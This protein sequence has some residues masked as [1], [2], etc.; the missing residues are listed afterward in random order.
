MNKRISPILT[1]LA[2]VINAFAIGSTEFISVGL[3]PLIVNS[4]HVTL[5][6]AGL[7]VSLYAIGVTIGAPL[8]T[9]L[10]GK[11]NR[12]YLMIVIML[13]FIIGNLVAA[14]ALSFS[15]LLGGRIISALAHGLFMS[16][17]SV[18]AADVVEPNK[19]ASAIA[20][21][22]TGLTVAT[23]T[24]VPLG[25][26][27]GQ[28]TNWHFTFIFIAIIGA[29]GL[30]ANLF[31]IP[32][33]LPIPGVVDLRGIIRIFKNKF[34]LGS[35]IVTALGY[36]GTFAAYTYL[37]PILEDKIGYSAHAVVLL[38]VVYG[39]M[40]AIGN[41]IGG[42][43][44]NKQ[45]LKSLSLMFG[46]LSLSLVFLFVAILS[47]QLIL[48]TLA[49]LVLGLFSFMNVPGLQLYVVQLAE[50]YTPKDI[51]LAS[52]FNISAF[53][54]GIAFGSF[55]GA[56]VTKSIGVTYTPIFGAIIVLLA[57]FLVLQLLHITRKTSSLKEK[58][59]E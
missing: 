17:S 33:H 20:I 42:H 57:V 44:S 4:F 18:I 11:W 24:G 2:L 14:F 9:V 16:V 39:I 10:T 54:I 3:M 8:L 5:A 47:N 6:Q 21:M 46:L 56:Q 32:K 7:T 1:L 53:N 22:F 55:V 45:P 52:A 13:L 35:F 30:V 37:T 34:L 29:L 58:T 27:I 31:L 28:Q 43:F 26:F 51:T 38:L 40:V 50:E 23:V 49:T 19:R 36:G 12:K 59:A 41:T 48:A 25:T 15:M